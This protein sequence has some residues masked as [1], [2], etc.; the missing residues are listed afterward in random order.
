MSAKQPPETTTTT[1]TQPQTPS[2][3][4]DPPV[5]S[6]A[7]ILLDH[8]P[9]SVRIGALVSLFFFVSWIGYMTSGQFMGALDQQAQAIAKQTV[10]QTAAAFV[11]AKSINGAVSVAATFTVGAG[12]LVNGSI[13]PGKVLD[14]FDRLIDDFSDYLLIAASA[15]TLTQLILIIDGSVGFSIVVP[16]C[17]LLGFLVYLLRH[18]RT[19]WQFH[20]GGL[21]Q[22]TLAFVV[23]LRFGLPLAMIA[24]HQCYDAF[25]APHY[26]HAQSELNDIQE[27]TKAM[28]TSITNAK[29]HSDQ[30]L[31]SRWFDTASDKVDGVRAA[32]AVLKDNFEHFFDAI[33]TMTA[34]MA[35]EILFL[36]IALGWV[37]WKLTRRI[38][39]ALWYRG[40]VA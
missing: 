12:A 29:D 8:T 14:P 34:I 7:R 3:P 40:M 19:G 35:L 36:P 38:T 23:L 4:P 10:A 28:Y 20:L 25:L 21:L 2:P 37:L 9:R 26:N 11:I 39:G 18:H 33:F 22:A 31:L 6:F 32:A 5:R 15:A 16:F 13:E 27:Q 17:F 1:T 24:S 30:W